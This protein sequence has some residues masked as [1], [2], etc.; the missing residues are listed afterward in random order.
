MGLGVCLSPSLVKKSDYVLLLKLLISRVETLRRASSM[1][2]EA[3]LV[4][5]QMG[6]LDNIQRCVIPRTEA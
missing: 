1:G 6:S 2:E 5:F 4:V 3:I